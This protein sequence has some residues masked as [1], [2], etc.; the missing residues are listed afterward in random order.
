MIASMTL[1]HDAYSLHA[2]AVRVMTE[3]L[4][5]QTVMLRQLVIPSIAPLRR[6]LANPTG[7]HE[8]TSIAVGRVCHVCRVSQAEGE[9]DD[10]VACRGE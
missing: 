3:Q 8:W 1:D 7:Q 4:K 2:A 6:R 5:A 9:F 10:S